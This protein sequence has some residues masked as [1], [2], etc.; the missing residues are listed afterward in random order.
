MSVQTFG[1]HGERKID[2]VAG[3]KLSSSSHSVRIS[4]SS[5]TQDI[6]FRLKEDVLNASSSYPRIGVGE[7]VRNSFD[8]LPQTFIMQATQEMGINGNIHNFIASFLQ[9]RTFQVQVGS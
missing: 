8:S 4:A 2:V 9:D 1:E 7:D 3:G 6:M 5:F